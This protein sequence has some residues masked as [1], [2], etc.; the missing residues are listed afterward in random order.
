MTCD[1]P[2]GIGNE[3]ALARHFCVCAH[4]QPGSQRWAC[5]FKHGRL[6]RRAAWALDRDHL[7]RIIH[8]AEQQRLHLRDFQPRAMA[9]GYECA[10]ARQLERA[11]VDGGLA[12]LRAHFQ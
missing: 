12:G 11:G 5:S 8:L 10:V 3:H 6:V 4:R 2:A 1:A 9:H 7:Q